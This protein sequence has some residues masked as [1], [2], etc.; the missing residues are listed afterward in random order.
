MQRPG[1]AHRPNQTSHPRFPVLW[2]RALCAPSRAGWY[3]NRIPA[4]GS[5]AA[6]KMPPRHTLS[7]SRCPTTA[8]GFSETAKYAPAIS[9]GGTLEPEPILDCTVSAPTVS[10]PFRSPQTSSSANPALTPAYD[11]ALDGPKETCS[12]RSSTDCLRSLNGPG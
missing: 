6:V 3:H 2:G 5:T 11:P 8:A 1:G 4:T 9:D 12:S 10:A 7:R